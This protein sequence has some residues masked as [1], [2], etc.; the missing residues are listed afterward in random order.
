MRVHLLLA[1]AAA[2]CTEATPVARDL[3]GFPLPTPIAK[4]D[5]TLTATDGQPYSF[6]ERTAGK[7]TLLFFGYLNCPDVCPVHAANLSTV[8]R[9]LSGTDRQHLTFVFVTTDPDRDSLSAL[10]K[11]LNNFDPSFVG[12]RGPMDEVNAILKGMNLPEAFSGEKLSTGDYAVG[13]AAQVIAFEMD[14]TARVVY[15]FGIRQEDWAHDLPK[16]LAPKR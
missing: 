11:W 16:L 5:F 9:Q 13:H 4:P 7:L 8:I 12:L 14:D 10:R 15:P 6:R 2:A 3:R 1:V